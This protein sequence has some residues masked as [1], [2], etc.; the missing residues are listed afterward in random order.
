MKIFRTILVIVF[1]FSTFW[2]EIEKYIKYSEKEKIEWLAEDTDTEK[3]ENSDT[4]KDEEKIV[5]N[6][7]SFCVITSSRFLIKNEN[8]SNFYLEITYCSGFKRGHYS[9]PDIG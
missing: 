3:Q 1:I 4:E 9:P 7:L 5:E 2:S 8:S 6:I